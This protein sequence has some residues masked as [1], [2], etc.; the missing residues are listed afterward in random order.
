[1]TSFLEISWRV[2]PAA[3][4]MV[5]GAAALVHGVRLLATGGRERIDPDRAYFVTRGIRAGIFGLCVATIGAGWLWQVDWMVVLALVIL[6]EEM[7]ET[8]IM[9]A[10]LRD[11]R[12][13]R[14]EA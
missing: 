3:L 11:Q 4:W 5:A 14:A 10:A 2:Y 13:A 12:R 8:S 9:T 6:G 7:L 1:M